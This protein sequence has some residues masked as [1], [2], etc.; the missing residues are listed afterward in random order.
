M[1]EEIL[2]RFYGNELKLITQ[3]PETKIIKIYFK[4]LNTCDDD[5]LVYDPKRNIFWMDTREIMPE[6][7]E[8]VDLDSW[9]KKRQ[10]KALD[11]A[12]K[13]ID[14]IISKISAKE[15]AKWDMLDKQL[16]EL[17]E[18]H[19]AYLTKLKSR[20]VYPAFRFAMMCA[21]AAFI[22]AYLLCK[23]GIL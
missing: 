3:D 20:N 19:E 23:N 4:R 12:D 17:I 13:L 7:Q 11:D 6:K 1:Q 2:N 8:T 5:F 9:V 14:P 16:D 18:T 22:L 21:A 15:A 10:A